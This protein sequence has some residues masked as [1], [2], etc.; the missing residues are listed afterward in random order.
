MEAG[1]DISKLKFDVVYLNHKNKSKHKTF[2]NDE[3]GFD[4]FK[5]WIKSVGALK[6]HYCMEATGRYGEALALFLSTNDIKVSVINPTRIKAF[7][8]SEGVR[9]KTDKVDA[10]VIARF[11]KA[12][13]PETWLPPSSQSQAIRDLYRCLQD[14]MD[15]KQRCENRMEKLANN[16]ASFKTWTE[17]VEAYDKKIIQIQKQIKEFIDLDDDLGKKEGL[18]ESIKGIGFKSAIALLSELPDITV[19]KN[20]KELAAFAGLTPSV[21]QSG[22][23]L[24]SN[25]SLSKAGNICLRKALYMPTLVAIRHNPTIKEFYDRLLRK[26]KKKMVAI[27]AAMRKL[28]HVIFGVLKHQ[29]PFNSELKT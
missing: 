5:E 18:L 13:C 29:K 23:S 27:A 11:C 2:S 7:A 12:H 1:I 10:G 17:M 21:R 4:E 8:R 24:H 28:L 9:V 25:G 14:L 20:A 22:S 3:K 19:F 16:K 15:D 26:G 6:A